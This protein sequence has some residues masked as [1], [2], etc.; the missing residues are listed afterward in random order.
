[1]DTSRDESARH[2]ER[3]AGGAGE[4]LERRVAAIEDGLLAQRAILVDVDERLVLRVVR[5][6]EGRRAERGG[7][8][9]GL[10]LV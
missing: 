8:D 7:S 4:E 9:P 3:A 1:M 6:E 10:T 2:G 5:E